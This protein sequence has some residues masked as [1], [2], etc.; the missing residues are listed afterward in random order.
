MSDSP[1]R[2]VQ[3]NMIGLTMPDVDVWSDRVVTVLGQNPGAFTGPGTNTYLVGTSSRPLLLDTGDGNP[4]YMPFLIQGLRDHRN[5]EELQG[6]V[7]THAHPDHIGGITN[8]R[9]HF[10]DLITHKRPWEGMDGPIDGPVE[11]IDGDAVIETEGATLRA[12]FTPGHACDHLCYWLEE[13]RAIFTGDVVLGAGTTVIPE[14]GGDL[15]DYMK[16]LE[17]LLEWEP[18]VLYP[19]H[20]PVIRNADEKIRQYI[21][22]RNLREEQILDVLGQGVSTVPEMVKR[23]YADV[24][25]FLWPAAGTSVRSHLGKLLREKIVARSDEDWSIIS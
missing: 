22:H 2:V 18:E 23:I 8:V 12:I 16:S 4:A 9:E 5:S 1:G 3:G 17:R 15:F 6:I 11:A 21:A 14:H 24:P 7:A 10:G 13:E 19:A 20:G 25:E